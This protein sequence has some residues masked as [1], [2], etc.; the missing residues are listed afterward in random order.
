MLRAKIDLK[1]TNRRELLSGMVDVLMEVKK[2]VEDDDDCEPNVYFVLDEI[3]FSKGEAPFAYT[4][5]VGELE[6]NEPQSD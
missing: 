6:T 5:D 3:R 2:A 4:L 1:A